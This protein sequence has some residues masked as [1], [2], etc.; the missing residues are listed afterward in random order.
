MIKRGT[1]PTLLAIVAFIVCGVALSTLAVLAMR[2]T[3]ASTATPARLQDLGRRV[4]VIAPHPDDEVLATGGTIHRLL[5]AGAHVRVV[6]V[7]AGDSYYNAAA[8]I[9]GG[10]P[11]AASYL[12]LG[13]QRHRESLAAI[14]RLGLAPA[15]VVYLGYADSTT[16]A[17]W[18]RSW[19]SSKPAVGR[20]GTSTVPYVWAARP[21]IP[22]CGAEL[23]A[24]LE[25]A[26]RDFAPDT[27]ITPDV[28]ETHPDHAAVAAFANYAMDA[29]GFTGRR[30]ST[31]VHFRRYPYPWGHLPGSALDP[32]PNLLSPD[33]TWL[34]L[35]VGAGDNAAKAA[36]IAEYRSQTDINDM[37]LY[38][39]TYIRTN[40][41]FASRVPARILAGASDS[42]PGDAEATTV[43]MTPRPVV[44]PAPGST[45][46]WVAAI[47]MARGAH[48][49]WVGLRCDA[50]V[51]S[52][53]SFRL[54]VLLFGGR[55]PAR[56]DVSVRGA[57]TS[58]LRVTDLSIAPE[59]VRSRVDGDT[60]WIEVPADMVAGRTR[61]M[62]GAAAG[63]EGTSPLPTAWREAEL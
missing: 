15:D 53:D 43:C 60:L 62:V 54:G 20:T 34:S 56:L 41:L 13:E 30:L 47:R 21:G 5:A 46:P 26:V 28:Y 39:R 51:A 38:M 36:A 63:S 48:T 45:R 7:T 37:G 12:A 14:A 10:T 40:E 42:M 25:S 23:A 2:S 49:L 17:M 27:V 9:G 29:V 32:P 59:G 24:D 61:C 16:A 55:T 8:L 1:S 3:A 52:G 18:D 44:P 35:P 19:S 4:L 50:P 6:V 31:V 58:V 22:Q 57:A 33:T 11:D